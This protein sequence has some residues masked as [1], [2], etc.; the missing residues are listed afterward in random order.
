MSQDLLSK[1]IRNYSHLPFTKEL[2]TD[3][4]KNK[5][6]K[7]WVLGSFEEALYHNDLDAAFATA[8]PWNQKLLENLVGITKMQWGMEHWGWP[9]EPKYYQEW[10][11]R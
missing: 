1:W 6:D 11:N 2:Q 5:T 3:I 4:A 10:A 7:R 8:D 9:R